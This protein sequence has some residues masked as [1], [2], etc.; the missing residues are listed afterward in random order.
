MKT[1]CLVATVLVAVCVAD[2][3]AGLVVLVGDTGDGTVSVD[4]GAGSLDLP[5]IRCGTGGNDSRG[6]AS[7]FFFALPALSP[8][9][10][11][12]GAELEVG[13]LGIAHQSPEFNVD[14]FGI[15]ARPNAIIEASDYYDGIAALSPDTLL[16]TA[17]IRPST[18][19]GIRS[20]ENASLLDFVT[21]LYSADGT[22]VSAFATFRFNPDKD[23]P[24][25]SFPLR[26]YTLATAE[27][28][29]A[30]YRPQLSLTTADAPVPE[31]STLVLFAGLGVMGL[32]MAWQR[33]RQRK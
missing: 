25:N 18:T 15:D 29:N 14:A 28:A 9:S 1:A 7:I 33:K 27:N 13:Y 19:P 12:I 4:G 6:V 16:Q 3:T 32:A 30:S 11:I 10:T 24:V 8:G 31:P 17:I 21:T 5:G 20:I 23:L 22:P 2:A 26:G